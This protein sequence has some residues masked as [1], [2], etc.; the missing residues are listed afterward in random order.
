[1]REGRRMKVGYMRGM[2]EGRRIISGGREG[3]R[4]EER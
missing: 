4:K 2:R 1:M 3:E